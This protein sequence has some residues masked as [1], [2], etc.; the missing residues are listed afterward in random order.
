VGN[1]AQGFVDAV[2]FV[3][4]TEAIRR[5]I[6]L[7]CCCGI[8]REKTD[9]DDETVKL[10]YNRNPYDSSLVNY[11]PRYSI[12]SSPV[13]VKD[14]RIGRSPEPTTSFKEESPSLYNYYF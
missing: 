6:K 5:R 11:G 12:S 4:L 14:L 13:D 8:Q 1:N 9:R 3:A 2:I 7:L 10:N